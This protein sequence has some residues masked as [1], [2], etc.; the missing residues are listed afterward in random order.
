M[1]SGRVAAV[2]VFIFN[3]DVAY[4]TFASK[5]S[6]Q[7]PFR[8]HGFATTMPHSAVDA[9]E[10]MVRNP[11]VPISAPVDRSTTSINILVCLEASSRCR[12]RRDAMASS[13]SGQRIAKCGSIVCRSLQRARTAESRDFSGRQKRRRADEHT[14]SPCG[15]IVP[16]VRDPQNVN[17]FGLPGRWRNTFFF[18]QAFR[19]YACKISQ[20]T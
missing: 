7:I 13:E 10:S 14:M 18:Q 17:N 12:L 8:C 16:K 19:T 6:W 11:D 9:F 4:S 3:L 5:L 15:S 1:L 2:I 20:Y